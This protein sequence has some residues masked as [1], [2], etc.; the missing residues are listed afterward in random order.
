MQFLRRSIFRCQ[1][2]TCVC[3]DRIAER[4]SNTLRTHEDYDALKQAVAHQKKCQTLSPWP[5]DDLYVEATTEAT[6]EPT[7]ATTGRFAS[8]GR[9]ERTRK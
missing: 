6:T 7:G 3:A 8:S 2:Q 9:Q 5:T 4:M 1:R